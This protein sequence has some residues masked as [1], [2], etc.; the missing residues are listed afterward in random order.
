LRKEKRSRRVKEKKQTKEFFRRG[1][2]KDVCLMGN[3]GIGRR[4]YIRGWREGRGKG[5]GGN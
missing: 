2:D 3:L 5:S 4:P 1:V